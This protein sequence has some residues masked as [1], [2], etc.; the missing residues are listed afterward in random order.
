MWTL[1][2]Y[3]G[4][5][6]LHQDG[7]KTFLVKEAMPGAFNADVLALERGEQPVSTI[8]ETDT[9]TG[10]A[11]VFAYWHG[12]GAFTIEPVGKESCEQYVNGE[13]VNTMNEEIWATDPD[14]DQ[15]EETAETEA[16]EETAVSA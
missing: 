7:S 11:T 6:Y 3:Q 10:T 9:L 16:A 1:L 15:D 2:G 4:Q 13:G 12:Q 8:T 14:E 5:M